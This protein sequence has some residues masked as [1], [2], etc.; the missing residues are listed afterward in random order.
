MQYVVGVTKSGAKFEE[1][2][3]A[4]RGKALEVAYSYQNED[5]LNAD[6]EEVISAWVDERNEMA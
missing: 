4:N 2:Y 1:F 3:G 6:G 5:E